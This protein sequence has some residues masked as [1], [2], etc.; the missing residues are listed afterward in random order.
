MISSRM[1]RLMVY[2]NEFDLE[3]LIA[4]AAGTPGELKETITRPDLIHQIIDAYGEVLPNLQKHAEGWPPVESLRARVMSGN[5]ASRPDARR[6][7][8]TIRRRRGR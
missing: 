7:P 5:P 4:T 6:R 3:L 1:I 8:A 2:A